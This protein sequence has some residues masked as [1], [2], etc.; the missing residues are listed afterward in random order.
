MNFKVGDKIVHIYNHP[1]YER[2]LEQIRGKIGVVTQVDRCSVQDIQALW[3][4]DFYWYV[5]S[6]EVRLAR[7]EELR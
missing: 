1:R 2:D 7:P 5:I 6:K 3:D 4:N